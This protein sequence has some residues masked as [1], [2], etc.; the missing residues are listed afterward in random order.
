MRARRPED[1]EGLLGPS[2]VARCR[3]AIARMPAADRRL[4]GA[5]FLALA[6]ETKRDLYLKAMA[7]TAS[8]WIAEDNAA[9]LREE[10]QRYAAAISPMSDADAARASSIAARPADGTLREPRLYQ[11]Y[12]T[13]CVPSAVLVAESEASPAR[14]LALSDYRTRGAAQIDLLERYGGAATARADLSLG[15]DVASWVTSERASV[16]R[17]LLDVLVEVVSFGRVTT[18]SF[19]GDRALTERLAQR[20]LADE[21]VALAWADAGRAPSA[22]ELTALRA[23]YAAA[24]A[25]HATFEAFLAA[26]HKRP[27]MV[28]RT[29]LDAIAKDAGAMLSFHANPYSSLDSEAADRLF[30][31]LSEERK[32]QLDVRS[33]EALVEH[34]RADDTGRRTLAYIRARALLPRAGRDDRRVLADISAG[35]DPIPDE[36]Q[37]AAARRVLAETGGALGLHDERALLT[38]L[39]FRYGKKGMKMEELVPRLSPTTGAQYETASFTG[40]AAQMDRITRALREGYDVPF[41]VE[42]PAHAMIFTDVRTTPAGRSFLIQDPWTGVATWASETDVTSG[43][44]ALRI[45]LGQPTPLAQLS[46]VLPA[47]LRGHAGTSATRLTYV[48]L[49]AS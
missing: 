47:F 41:V 7:A 46:A 43:R 1:A 25:D 39:S 35:R 26:A 4:C 29:V 3:D 42:N 22:T 36:Q 2:H 20:L 37:V 17:W 34:M 38:A 5:T 8:R 33:P 14:G 11:Q 27:E 24:P 40:R 23:V 9:S 31:R 32:A 44:F 12:L 30:E 19:N 45:G 28:H 10:L 21:R 16:H 48:W 49:P 15:Y 13:T 18:F 6:S